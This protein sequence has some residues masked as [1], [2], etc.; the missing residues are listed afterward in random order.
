VALN[1][2]F[3]DGS[4]GNGLIGALSVLL[5]GRDQLHH[6]LGNADAVLLGGIGVIVCHCYWDGWFKCGRG[7][8]PH[9]QQTGRFPFRQVVGGD[10]LLPPE[11]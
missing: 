5:N 7:F 1:G 6:L 4:K 9:Q 2:T 8:R 10:P 11:C 3:H